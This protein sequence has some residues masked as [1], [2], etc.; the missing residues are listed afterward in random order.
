MNCN[1]ELFNARFEV[2]IGMKIRSSGCLTLNGWQY[3]RC[4]YGNAAD[5]FTYWMLHSTHALI[6][7]LL[8]HQINIFPYFD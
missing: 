7:A 6:I 4:T 3:V 2:F 5:I 1:I 8:Y